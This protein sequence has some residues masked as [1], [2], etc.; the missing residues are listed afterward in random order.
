[1]HFNKQQS[2]SLSSLNYTL[3]SMYLYESYTCKHTRDESA[4]NTLYPV[5][6]HAHDTQRL[7]AKHFTPAPVISYETAN[8]QSCGETSS[9]DR[10]SV[11]AFDF[12]SAAMPCEGCGRSSVA[13]WQMS[14]YV[15]LSSQPDWQIQ[16]AVYLKNQKN[17][18]CFFSAVQTCPHSSSRLVFR[19]N[20][21]PVRFC[22]LSWNFIFAT[23]TT[24]MLR[25]VF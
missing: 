12:V 14:P 6:N 3:T 8:M 7:N 19:H 20:L 11:S 16:V 10:K 9:P 13:W 4:I 15:W 2:S 22:D 25:A 5:L 1:M 17:H 23:T 24:L 18:F 21:W